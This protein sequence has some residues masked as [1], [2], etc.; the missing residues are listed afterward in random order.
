MSRVLVS[1]LVKTKNDIIVEQIRDVLQASSL[2]D[3]FVKALTSMERLQDM[4]VFNN[5]SIKIDMDKR[6]GREREGVE[7][8]FLVQ[9]LGWIKSTM[10]AHA[11]TQSG[12]AVSIQ[13]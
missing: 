8:T 10:S 6:G 12:D 2:K 3:L 4:K 9:E 13:T 5:V 7:V 1:G 11:G